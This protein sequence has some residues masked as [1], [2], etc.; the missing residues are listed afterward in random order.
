MSNDKQAK[1]RGKVVKPVFDVSSPA[2]LYSAIVAVLTI[3]AA[4]GVTFPASPE[5]ISGELTNLLSTSGF[6]ALI[7]VAV[8]SVFFPIYNAWK[9]G[10]LNFKGVFSSTLTWVAIAVLFFDALALFG[11]T[12]PP[13]TAE[14]LVYFIAAKDWGSLISMFASVI[15][16]TVVR[17]I[18][19]KRATA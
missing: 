5:E 14:Q 16:P 13:G 18:K 7:G 11:L 3:L 9:K 15:V 19:D 4:S 8:S 17:F 6:W 1:M 12:F 2:F 10:A